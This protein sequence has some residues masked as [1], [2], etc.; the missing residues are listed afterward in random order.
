MGSRATKGREEV[1]FPDDIGKRH[2]NLGLVRLGG[3]VRASDVLR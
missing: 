2:P 1:R 3:T